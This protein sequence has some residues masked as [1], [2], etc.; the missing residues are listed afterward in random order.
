MAPAPTQEN[1]MP[2]KTFIAVGL[3]VGALAASQA[4]IAAD[5]HY[6]DA[7]GD[8]IDERLDDKGDR[9]DDRLDRRSALA[10]ANG[11]ERRANH[12]DRKGDRI[13]NRLDR[14]GNR[15]NARLD[16]RSAHVGRRRG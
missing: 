15:I 4:A 3:L 14:K 1:T 9:I 8:R 11:H 6:L 10:E 5:G 2:N 16:R 12:L 7:K 13:D